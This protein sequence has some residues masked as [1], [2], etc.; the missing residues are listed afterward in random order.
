MEQVVQKVEGL[1]GGF[2]VENFFDSNPQLLYRLGEAHGN[3]N[4]APQL[5]K[6]IAQYREE[7]AWLIFIRQWLSAWE[8]ARGAWIQ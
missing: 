8:P 1:G 2:K 7:I 3:P 6:A 4:L 5:E